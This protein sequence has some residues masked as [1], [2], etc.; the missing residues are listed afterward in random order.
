MSKNGAGFLVRALA[1]MTDTVLLVTPHILFGLWIAGS[2]T[3]PQLGF[4]AM[5]Y[6]VVILGVSLGFIFFY[7]YLVSRFGATPGKLLTGLRITDE[8]GK[9]LSL[10]RSLFRALVGYP[11][12]G[13]YFGLGYLSIIRDENKQGWHD[14]A[15]KSRVWIVRSL[16][17]LALLLLLALIGINGY[18]GYTVYQRFAA[19]PL[20]GQLSRAGDTI[21]SK[22]APL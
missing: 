22:T 20:I 21:F 4:S 10:R 15:V 14:K 12:A 3:L 8:E 2:A 6:L 7:P 17:P 19:G 18:L 11:F 9:L 1:S 16:W 13:L 5:T